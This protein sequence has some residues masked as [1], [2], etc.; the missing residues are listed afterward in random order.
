MFGLISDD[1]EKYNT[2]EELLGIVVGAQTIPLVEYD[3]AAPTWALFNLIMAIAG[4][5]LAGE[6][7]LMA[8]IK[9]K[10]EENKDEE[11]ARKKFTKKYLAV[12][13]LGIIGFILFALTQDMSTKMVV[14]DV[15]SVLQAGIF[16]GGV[17]IIALKKKERKEISAN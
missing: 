16:A 11:K 9:R 5:I 15:W 4:V 8:L 2:E 3:A 10:E 7:V 17:I 12:I 14:F 13:L 1:A 6:V